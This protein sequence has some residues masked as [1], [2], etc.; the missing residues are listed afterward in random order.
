[1]YMTIISR[2]EVLIVQRIKSPCTRF[3]DKRHAGCHAV[4]EVYQEY[5]KLKHEEYDRRAQEFI[6]SAYLSDKEYKKRS[7]G[8][9]SFGRKKVNY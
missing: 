5:E 3:C 1:M 8:I 9:H 2:D 7:K 6:N 4:C